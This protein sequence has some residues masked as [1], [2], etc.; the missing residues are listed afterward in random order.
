MLETER[1]GDTRAQNMRLRTPEELLL[2]GAKRVGLKR[3]S[4]FWIFVEPWSSYE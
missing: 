4:I 3:L 2:R 1:E